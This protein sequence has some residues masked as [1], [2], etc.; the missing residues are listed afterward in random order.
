MWAFMSH[1]KTF[2]HNNSMNTIFPL[3]VHVNRYTWMILMIT[4]LSITHEIEAMNRRMIT[5]H[6][7][8]FLHKEA[9]IDAFPGSNMHD[10]NRFC[11]HAIAE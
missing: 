1:Y 9:G 4:R 8:N 6:I 3:P 7:R 5:Q 11:F 10:Y 2:S